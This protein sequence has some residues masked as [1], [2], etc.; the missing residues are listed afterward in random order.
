MAWVQPAPWNAAQLATA[1]CSV[2]S[3]RGSRGLD[4]D[5][6]DGAST[7]T[8][9]W[10]RGCAWDSLGVWIALLIQHLLPENLEAL[11]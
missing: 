6:L 5:T 4:P 10:P 7:R 8:I 11:G 3:G 1:Q 2:I 9:T